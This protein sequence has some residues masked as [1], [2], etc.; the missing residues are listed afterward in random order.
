MAEDKVEIVLDGKDAGLVRAWMSAKASVD[1]FENS[2]MKIDPS[3]RK[4]AKSARDFQ[5]AIS[6]TV[7]SIA[8]LAAGMFSVNA[9]V[10]AVSTEMDRAREATN[11]FLED[12][13]EAFRKVDRRN[14]RLQV[15]AGLGPVG[16]EDM[17]RQLSQVGQETATSNSDVTEIALGLSSSGASPEDLPGG[18]KSIASFINAQALGE[19]ANVEQLT[20]AMTGMIL[21][22]GKKLTQE[23]IDK[24]TSQLQ[25]KTVKDTKFK[26]TDLDKWARE[27]SAMKQHGGMTQEDIIALAAVNRNEV[28]AATASNQMRQLVQNMNISGGKKDAVEALKKLGLTSSDVDMVGEDWQTAFMRLRKG[29]DS[30]PEEKRG[31]YLAKISEGANVGR[32]Y[33]VTNKMEEIQQTKAGLEKTDLPKDA[34]IMQAGPGAGAV[35]LGN[36]M[37]DVNARRQAYAKLY[38]D[39]LET[40]L[41]TTNYSPNYVERRMMQYD[42]MIGRGAKPEQ[43]TKSAGGISGIGGI[44]GSGLWDAVFENGEERDRINRGAEKRFITAVGGVGEATKLRGVP[45]GSTIEDANSRGEAYARHYEQY[46]REGKTELADDARL[47]MEIQQEILR[48]LKEQN[49]LIRNQQQTPK[50]EVK[51]NGVAAPS[52]VKAPKPV[53]ASA[54]SSS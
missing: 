48:T 42:V 11:R 9:I 21:A 40:E 4:N 25:S 3:Q 31:Q 1:S 54:L 52:K 43:A 50:V 17:Q 27:A 19:E 2:L 32:F 37:E 23:N 16:A 44:G 34:G 35:R 33:T 18:T 15:T 51:V 5:S 28:D 53:A 8:S 13:E 47:N 20:D 26:V 38:R 30:V 10:G 39:A 29:L 22:Q 14:R 46:A 6:D 7:S 12:S 49:A 36:Q 24:L 45:E 41:K